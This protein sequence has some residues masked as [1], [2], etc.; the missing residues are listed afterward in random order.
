[1]RG[2]GLTV[3]ETEKLR[4][5]K[6]NLAAE[7]HRK[8]NVMEIVRGGIYDRSENTGVKQFFIPTRRDITDEL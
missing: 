7:Y 8:Q 4:D 3:F 1:M 6:H 5:M 2:A